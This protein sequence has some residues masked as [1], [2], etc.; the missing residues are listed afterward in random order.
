MTVEPSVAALRLLV[1]VAD[2][3][4]LGAGARAVGMAQSNASRAL[5]TLERQL[6]LTLVTR[7]SA[8]SAMTGDG[9][10]TVEWARSVV[11]A[12]DR[13]AEGTA[14]LRGAG[15]DL[16]VAASMT[17]AENLMPSWL[18]GLR[19]DHPEVAARF[20]AASGQDGAGDQNQRGIADQYVAVGNWSGTCERL[21]S[22]E[23][24]TMI[25]A[26]TEDIILPVKNSLILAEAIE[27]SWLVRLKDGG[28]GAIYQFPERIADLL[29]TF[30]K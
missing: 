21:K 1:A 15:K 14:A 29:I 2:E 11:D 20:T 10:L 12:M 5:A 25:I 28:H 17:I 13:L 22:I 19:R 24:D 6:A 18:A 7:S 16:A 23:S 27:G 8:G 4:G 26:G 3:G 9:A 30:L